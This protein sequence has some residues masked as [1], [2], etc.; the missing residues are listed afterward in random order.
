MTDDTKENKLVP[1]R[2]V[3]LVILDG[4]GINPSKADNAISLAKT[5]NLDYY[6][7]HY[8]HTQLQA[9]GPAVG[10][11]DGQMGN[12]EV[13]HMALGAGA[14]IDQDLMRIQHAIDHGDFFN[15]P[16]LNAALDDAKQR[17]RPVHLFGLV[18]DG[19]VH[20]DVQHLLALIHMCKLK[21][22]KP[23]LH[24]VT[25]GRDTAPRA[26]LNYLP[27]VSTALHECGGAIATIT[28]RY[29]AMD[30]DNRWERTELA[31]RAIIHGKGQ[32][33]QSADTALHSAYAS[34][35]NDE[36]IRP[37][38][39]PSWQ[40]PEQDDVLIS[41]NF[42]KDRPQQIVAALGLPD[43]GGF[44]RGEA[45]LFKVTCM[46][47]YNRDFELPY[48]FTPQQPDTTLAQII[49]DAGLNQFHCAETEKYP[50]VT[51]FFNGGLAD[52]L[53][54][55]TH[56]MIPSPKVATYDQKPEMSAAWVTEAV[57]DA[58]KKETYGFI[59]VN[60]AN[61]DMVGHTAKHDAVIHAVETLDKEVGRLLEAAIP[62]GFSV[63]VTA[64]HGNCEE[65]IDPITG[66]AHTQH[67][68]YP[69]PC[70]IIDESRW[71][72]S[73]SGGLSNV[74]PTVLHLMGLAKPAAMPARSL[75]LKEIRSA[76]I[77]PYSEQQNIG[78]K[79]A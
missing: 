34:G 6:F 74:A 33:M 29:Y 18:S 4:F 41:F 23:L 32:R 57:I 1:R 11:P 10:V 21:Q 50:H 38:L 73:C 69:V 53:P 13:G 54:G 30:R 27:E 71:Q 25:D 44:D 67:T 17:Q 26:A 7:S 37:I 43:F 75:L 2:P 39:L 79:S 48:A 8:P 9:S 16:A 59:V 65:L 63:I 68:L 51:Y 45:P 56:V 24:M 22:V 36:F 20:S 35:D 62:Q 40:A 47:P 15:N 19:G 76:D 49:S 42:R 72:L 70:I 55:E 12:S 28:G 66:E 14:I 61:G 5:P 58:M 64:D 46:M 31:W 78:L 77:D 52:P 60:Y 3:L